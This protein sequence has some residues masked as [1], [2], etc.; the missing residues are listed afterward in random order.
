[1]IINNI[2]EQIYSLPIF[3][4][5]VI[6]VNKLEGGLNNTVHQ[7]LDGEQSFAVKKHANFTA[8]KN[9]AYAFKLAANKAIAPNVYYQD[10]S[11]LVTEFIEGQLLINATLPLNTKI[12]QTLALA[13][14][15]HSI[16]ITAA[17]EF[18]ILDIKAVIAA[19]IEQVKCANA[20]KVSIEPKSS[21]GDEFN[22]YQS[23]T[24]RA[25]DLASQNQHDALALIH[26]DLNFTNVIYQ[27]TGSLL[28]D[29]ESCSIAPIGYEL[30]M[31]CA[32]NLIPLDLV[33]DICAQYSKLSTGCLSINTEVVTRYLV[34]AAIINAL[35]YLAEF[36]ERQSSIY[37]QK[38]I[39]Q[40]N[41]AE[42][43]NKFLVKTV[44][45]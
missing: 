29:F 23:I 38:A 44:S 8:L 20:E 39:E 16:P 4:N 5:K 41:Y 33:D 14:K 18:E 32:V 9:E 43:A 25:M 35:W 26:G 13:V 31:F 21:D 17:L 15:L 34:Q 28:I 45:P 30:A 27:S 2:S 11:W 12:A 10:E 1:M 36:R 40:F 37:K 42:L 24:Q 19:L 7:V 3:K 6:E 22:S